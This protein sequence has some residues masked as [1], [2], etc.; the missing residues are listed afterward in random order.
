[1]SANRYNPSNPLEV[2]L[3]YLEDGE[4]YKLSS[5]VKTKEPSDLPQILLDRLYEDYHVLDSMDYDG[6]NYE[7]V[8][9]LNRNETGPEANYRI[10][11]PQ[12]IAEEEAGPH[13]AP[14]ETQ[15]DVI[16]INSFWLPKGGNTVF[17]QKP[18]E[19]PESGAA[20]QNGGKRIRKSKRILSNLLYKKKSK[21]K[22]CYNFSKV[23]RNITRRMKHFY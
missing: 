23:K 20:N 10:I 16:R 17:L 14:L 7:L 11:I 15:V 18:E 9:L 5:R 8:F 6:K 1:M 22:K 4:I 3:K 19:K 2:K 21:S 13:A 12:Y